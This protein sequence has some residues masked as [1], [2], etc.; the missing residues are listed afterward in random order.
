MLAAATAPRRPLRR[1]MTL[2]RE[3]VTVAAR[4]VLAAVAMASRRRPA[5]AARPRLKLTRRI[6]ERS[7]PVH[8]AGHAALHIALDLGLD[9]VTIAPD[10]DSAGATFSGGEWGRPA[11]SPNEKADD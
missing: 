2:A 8:E 1:R 5:K 10:H 4:L 7:T 11:Q 6:Y 3:R 9:K